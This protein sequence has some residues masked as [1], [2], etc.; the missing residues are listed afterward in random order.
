MKLLY[1]VGLFLLCFTIS[2]SHGRKHSMRLKSSKAVKRHKLTT[3]EENKSLSSLKQVSNKTT[4]QRGAIHF[5]LKPG[6]NNVLNVPPVNPS[7]P[8]DLQ[9]DRNILS[10]FGKD[11]VTPD[12]NVIDSSSSLGYGDFSSNNNID[13]GLMLTGKTLAYDGQ[14]LNIVDNNREGL[15]GEVS[16]SGGLPIDSVSNS[17]EFSLSGGTNIAAPNNFFQENEHLFSGVNTIHDGTPA[18]YSDGGH[19]DLP[20]PVH[21]NQNLYDGPVEHIYKPGAQVT[22]GPAVHI[23]SHPPL[24]VNGGQPLEYQGKPEHVKVHLHTYEKVG[25]FGCG[26]CVTQK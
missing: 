22:N 1:C 3:K 10:Q 8:N 11:I 21:L 13:N 18:T 12:E 5:Y 9:V 6:S 2:S 25:K 4:S 17:G 15:G 14:P 26:S 16:L 24:H 23:P 20:V 7:P 19:G